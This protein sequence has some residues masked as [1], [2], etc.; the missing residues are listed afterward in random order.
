MSTALGISAVSAVLKNLLNGVLN[1]PN[2]KLGLVKVSALAPDIVQTNLDAGSSSPQVN[3]FLHQVTLNAAWRNV[4]LPS[5]ASNGTT[6]L[7]NPPLALDL[8]YLLTAYASQDCLAEA[9]LGYAVQSLHENPVLARSQVD[10]YLTGTNTPPSPLAALI[11]SGLD[12]QLEMI[13]ITPATLGRE[14]MAWLWTALKADYRPTF[15]FQ[16]SVVLIQNPKPAQSALPVLQ[17]KVA[18]QPNL[19]PSWSS[20]TAANP[21]N[22]QPAANLGDTVT[23]LGTNLSSVT[24]VVL[25]NSRLNLNIQPV[26]LPPSDASAGSLQF[27]VPDSDIAVS[28]AVV[29]TSPSTPVD[30]PA[31][32]YLLSAQASNGTDVVSTNSLP[33][34]IAPRIVVPP[35]SPI[36]PDAH[37]NATVTI[38]CVPL[39]RVGQQVSLSIGS[40]EAPAN[41]FSNGTNRVSFT[42]SSLQAT[43]QPVP[44]RLRVDGVD[45][46]IID[47][48]QTPPVFSGPLVQVN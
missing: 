33:L 6:R 20:L 10:F 48:T 18:A 29:L 8:H 44:V 35:Q 22:G 25:T 24:N 36:T 11:S 12:G 5:L 2:V 40:Q 17:R 23:V 28:P 32:L 30:L 42:F 15:P 19:G 41:A 43:N 37:G 16:V 13:K 9:L 26:V 4:E 45:S 7:S 39:L 21:P 34:A 47:T 46:P 14:E 31:G 27:T 38:S 1:D 3:L